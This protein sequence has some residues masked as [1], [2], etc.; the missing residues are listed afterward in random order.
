VLPAQLTAEDFK[1]YPPKAR[2]LAVNHLPLLRQLPLSFAPFLLKEIIAC[3]WKFPAEQVELDRQLAYL[4]AFSPTQLQQELARFAHLQLAAGAETF[5]WVHSPAQFL[6]QLSAHLWATHQTDEF[7]GASEQYIHKFYTSLPEQSLPVD[8]LGII[9]IGQDAVQNTYPLFKKLRPNGVYFTRVQPASGLNAILDAVKARGAAHPGDYAHWYIDG[10][11]AA[12]LPGFAIISY[13]A[14]SPTRNAL[15][16]K[17]LAAY[18]APKFDPE[19]LRST[20]A[21]VSPESL[22]VRGPS[23]DETL[24]RFALTLLTEGSGT[25]IYSTTFVQWAAR[26][27]LRRAQPLTLL[28]RYAPR[29]KERSMGDLLAGTQRAAATDPQGSL[30]DADMGAYYTWVNQQRLSGAASARFLVWFENG[31]EALVIA[32]GLKPGTIN[33]A[34]IGLPSLLQEYILRV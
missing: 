33:T 8:R 24:D 30:V 1:N 3:D 20:L 11:K 7:R 17:M 6:E 28:A 32:P 14:L 15:T 12:A 25:Q 2:G 16:A 4:E 22:G 27:I 23:G 34:A 29:Q 26:E 21:Q 5:D 10:G 19:L 31:N 18:E 13:D 9:V